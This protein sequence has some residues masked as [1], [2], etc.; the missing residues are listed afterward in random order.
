MLEACSVIK[1]RA[2]DSSGR[3]L[4][5]LPGFCSGGQQLLAYLAAAAAAAMIAVIRVC[6]LGC[7]SVAW[8]R[9]AR[10]FGGRAKAAL[11]AQSNP[12]KLEW[13]E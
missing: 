13:T 10:L 2:S 7:Q 9:W 4:Y 3:A 12:A 1:R 8:N 5:L 11:R 6:R